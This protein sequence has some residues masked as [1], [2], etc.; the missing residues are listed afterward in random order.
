MLY[1]GVAGERISQFLG[2]VPRMAGDAIEKGSITMPGSIFRQLDG[3]Y[4]QG[5]HGDKSLL[6]GLGVAL[7]LLMTDDERRVWM[8]R[9][10]IAMTQARFGST[11]TMELLRRLLEQQ[12]VTSASFGTVR[13]PAAAP[14][15]Q[16]EPVAGV[17]QS[18]A[19]ELQKVQDTAPA[20]TKPPK[21][22]GRRTA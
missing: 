21:R 10:S 15:P 7:L 22:D 20:R 5:K 19:E 8:E 11:S 3:L 17:A 4:R 14:T 12:G 2:E 13:P 16:A 18:V 6:V 1:T 9:F